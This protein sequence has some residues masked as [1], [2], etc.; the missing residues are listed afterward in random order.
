V[1]FLI[2]PLPAKLS[3]TALAASWLGALQI[4]FISNGKCFFV[5]PD[6]ISTSVSYLMYHPY[7]GLVFWEHVLDTIRKPIE[8][9]CGRNK[10][11]FSHQQPNHENAQSRQNIAK[12]NYK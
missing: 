7:L 12:T 5:L 8:I 4:C 1:Y 2:F 6:H 10:D 3:R 11:L 9:V